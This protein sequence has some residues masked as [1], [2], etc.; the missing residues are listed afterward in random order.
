M[1]YKTPH[2]K[3]KIEQHEPHKQRGWIWVLRKSGS[4][5]SSSGFHWLSLIISPVIG[6]ERGMDRIIIT[7]NGTHPWSFVAR[8]FRNGIVLVTPMIILR[9]NWNHRC[10]ILYKKMIIPDRI[11]LKLLYRINTCDQHRM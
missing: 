8:L 7:R 3:L 5:C 10:T 1:I 6:H 9:Y 11:I 4:S 2:R